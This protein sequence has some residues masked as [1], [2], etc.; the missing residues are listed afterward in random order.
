MRNVTRFIVDA[1][2]G[3]LAKWLRIAGYDALFIKDIDDDSL[4]RIG[5]EEGRVALTR[6]SHIP[7]RRVATSGTLKV[8]LIEC[9]KVEDQLQ[10]VAQALNLDLRCQPL[11]RCLLCNQALMPKTKEEVRELVPPYVFKTQ[12]HFSQCPACGRIYWRG[13]HWDNME[14]ELEKLTSSKGNLTADAPCQAHT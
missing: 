14:R 4:I 6:D 7:R 12:S 8:L 2:L 1:N 10:Q 5:L 13:T 11:S 9:D 3:K